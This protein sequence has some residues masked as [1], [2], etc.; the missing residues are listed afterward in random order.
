MVSH[1]IC[2]LLRY[3]THIYIFM[4]L[5]IIYNLS[6]K[7]F[8]SG[9]T[10]PASLLPFSIIGNNNLYLD[11]F[12]SYFSNWPIPWMVQERNGH[13]ISTYPIV[14]PI[15]ITPLYIIPIFILNFF[16][17][18]FDMT[19]PGFVLIVS[20]L[21]RISASTIAALSAVFIFLI[22]D[23][24]VKRKTAI[25]G[26]L[27]YGLS[28]STW[29]I[30]SQ[31]LWQH[32][33]S[34]LLLAIA[35]YV[36]LIDVKKPSRWF[37]LIIGL[38]SG[39]YVFNRPPD[40]ILLSPIIAYLL[41]YRRTALIYF[42]AGS[43]LSSA[44]F[45]IYNIYY[46]KNL[47]GGYGNL[48][49]TFSINLS[50]LVGLLISPNR[51]LFIFTP[52]AVLSLAGYIKLKKIIIIDKGI[53]FLLYAYG[54][55]ILTQIF[56]YSMFYCWWAGGSY[57][58]RFLTC[59]LPIISIYIGICLNNYVDGGFKQAKVK[60]IFIIAL[61][62]SSSFI[63]FVGAFYYPS[64]NWNGEPLNVDTN[65]E[66]IWDYKDSQIQRTFN[67]GPSIGNP[68][69]AIYII[70]SFNRDITTNSGDN[71]ITYIS[72]INNWHNLENWDGTPVR[73]MSNNATMV[74]L[75]KAKLN[76]SIEFEVISF[77]KPRTLEIYQGD[78]LIDEI[79]VFHDR[80]IWVSIITQFK[81]GENSI[82][83]QA[84][85]GCDYPKQVLGGEI[86]DPRCL[87]FALRNINI[88]D[89]N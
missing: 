69:K 79:N 43:I 9:D 82:R 24:L 33:T 56:V 20:V 23:T 80:F 77:N 36:L 73:W 53:R 2:D 61:I 17:Y 16:E 84:L 19:N 47:F 74:V 18:P 46:F 27:I 45:L 88:N 37:I 21:E 58:P 25:L 51:G 44:P 3:K 66:R 71:N 50:S 34:Q 86:N 87:S 57:G 1:R 70:F 49:S 4:L 68:I 54:P 10:L 85:E 12:A 67:A 60:S 89:I 78:I 11:Q 38:L 72:L 52:V 29:S 48:S 39:L 40:S 5:F 83:L 13:Y 75:A 8:E 59:I 76:H 14:T 41:L 42:I 31:E 30:S 55:A 32:G 7:L 64:G 81:E 28:T 15:I 62:F 22:L 65:P 63:Q 26:S 6:F 35:L